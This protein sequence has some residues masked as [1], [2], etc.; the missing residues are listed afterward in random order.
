MREMLTP[1]GLLG[2]LDGLGVGYVLHTHPPVFTVE[3]AQVHTAHLAG[4]HIKNLFLK[5]KD[6]LALV[7]A[8][9]DRRLDLKAL[10]K[11]MGQRWSFGSPELLRAT[12]GVEPGSVTPLALVNAAPKTLR[13]VLDAGILGYDVVNPHPLTNTMT[14]SM[15]VADLTRCLSAWGHGYEVVDLGAFARLG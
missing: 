2:L 3:E 1:E 5:D 13:V 8:L 7:V 10:G 11:H 12:L 14:V 6:A 15:A 9:D 4:A